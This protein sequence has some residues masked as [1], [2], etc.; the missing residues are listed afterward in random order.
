MS[1]YL[2][3]NGLLYVWGKI[4]S[5]LSGKVDKAEGM[6]LSSNDYSAE[7]KAKLAGLSNYVLPTATA[8]TLGGVKI[9]AGLTVTGGVLSAKSAVWDEIAGK[10]EL[11]LKTDLTGIY[12]FKGSVAAAGDLPA[13]GSQPGDVWNVETSG[14]NYAWDGTQWDA[15]GGTFEIESITNAE[16]DA[17]MAS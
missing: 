5:Q 17:L 14:M 1:K 15:L 4:K 7:D 13:S 3:N 9:G 16:I 12:K 6:G 8:E 10:P 2:D 11:A